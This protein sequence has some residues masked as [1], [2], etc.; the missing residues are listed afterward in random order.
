MHKR[1]PRLSQGGGVFVCLEKRAAINDH[2]M[3]INWAF[4]LA[5]TVR[6]D[7]NTAITWFQ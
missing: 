4:H 2:K 7:T 1:E 6:G 3:L 5:A